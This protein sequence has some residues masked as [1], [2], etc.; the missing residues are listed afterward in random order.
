MINSQNDITSNNFQIITST[1]NSHIK[2][3]KKLSLKKYRIENNLF[4]IESLSIINDALNAGFNFESLFVTNEFVAKHNDIIDALIKQ[5]RC[6]NLFLIDE[7]INRHYSLL[8]TASGITAV[9]KIIRRP[10]TD[11]PVIYLNSIN[12]PGNLG[13]IMRSALSFGFKNIV[14]DNNCTD[15]YNSKTINA[16]R[17]A[18]FKI[19][20][21]EDNHGVWLKNTKLPVYATSSHQGQP[22][23][24]FRPPS[25]F[26]LVLGSESH[27]VSQEIFNNAA[28]IIRIETFGQ[29]ESLNVASAAAILLYELKN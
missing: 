19:N 25:N 15:I 27:G 21:L 5:S 18:I 10:F 17:D 12:D 9:Y 1:Q 24:S 7:K 13:S 3:L 28:K 6:R 26:C 22:L 11:S 8:D 29:I 23:K 4:I 2:L 16:S 20:I 14:L